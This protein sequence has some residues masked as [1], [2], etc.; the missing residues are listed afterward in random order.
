MAQEA[1]QVA[2]VDLCNS[3]LGITDRR[4]RDIAKEGIVPAVE[5][6]KVPFLQTVKAVIEYYRK[7]AEA[8]G[9]LSLTDERTRLTRINADR[10]QLELEKER[11]DVISSAVAVKLWADICGNIKKKIEQIPTKLAPQVYGLKT[12]EIK[13]VADQMIYEVLKEIANPD[14]E[15]I[16]RQM[17]SRKGRGLRGVKHT[18][19]AGTVKRKP[20]GGRKK[21]VKSGGKRGTGEVVHGEG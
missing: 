1:R 20:V 11:G 13:A 10:K 21:G 5:K 16:A 4:Y 15:Q 14:L 7:R 9:S 17:G 19:A 18:K 8:G 6:G 2:I 12:P 3:V